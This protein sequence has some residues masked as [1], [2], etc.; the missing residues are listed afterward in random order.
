MV[1]EKEIL[2]H[3]GTRSELNA[4]INKRKSQWSFTLQDTLVE[5]KVCRYAHSNNIYTILLVI[6]VITSS[7]YYFLS[8]TSINNKVLGEVVSV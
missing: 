5:K 2:A 3:R 8:I 7:K 4:D 1:D 6:I